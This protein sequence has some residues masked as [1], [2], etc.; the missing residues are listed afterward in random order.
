MM[1]FLE[2]LNSSRLL[3]GFCFFQKGVCTSPA[4]QQCVRIAQIFFFHTPHM[5]RVPLSQDNRTES[6]Q[7]RFKR[8]E[9]TSTEQDKD[10][11]Q[12][13][14]TTKGDLFEKRTTT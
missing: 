9:N 10:A 7:P 3:R 1:Y 13:Q 4:S 11:S 14:A 6:G 8:K 5:S 2:L 12:Q